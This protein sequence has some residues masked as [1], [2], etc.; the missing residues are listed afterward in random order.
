M[1]LLEKTT[2]LDKTIGIYVGELIEYDMREGGFSIIKKEN[3]LPEKIIKEFEA[4]SKQQR[5]K[6]VGNLANSHGRK[7]KDV[8]RLLIDRFKYYREL[9]GELN[10]LKD[11]DIFYI[12]KDAICTKRYCYN[13]K[14]DDFI[15]FREK[16]VYGCYMR[17]EPQ[18]NDN[19]GTQNPPAIEFY[20]KPS[21]EVDV[22]GITDEHLVDHKNGIL[23]IVSK[24]MN[25]LYSMNYDGALRY[26]VSVMDAYKKGCG[27][28]IGSENPELFYRRFDSIAKYRIL[29]DGMVMDVDNIGKELIPICDK[30][31]NY[32]N[33]FI[34][35][36]NLVVK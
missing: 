12:R 2:Y 13:T 3:L 18:Y 5:H 8:P 29:Q 28:K 32:R 21:G 10:G 11:D 19:G 26:I 15:E 14:I 31:Y 9:F 4:L 25:Y 1:S 27:D 17:I 16:N 20:W 23:L 6:A 33:I 7:Y 36:M 34:P 24:F 22:K 30:A 35:M